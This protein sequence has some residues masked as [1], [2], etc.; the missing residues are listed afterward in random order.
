MV[1]EKQINCNNQLQN[2][3]HYVAV[4]RRTQRHGDRWHK[5]VNLNRNA[6][7]STKS[8]DIVRHDKFN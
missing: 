4:V 2:K 6:M 5:S 8:F 3:A 1:V 7:V